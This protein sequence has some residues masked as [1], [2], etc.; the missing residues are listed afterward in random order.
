MRTEITQYLFTEN[1]FKDVQEM[2]N[3]ANINLFA[4]LHFNFS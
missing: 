2:E 4:Q 1:V 3:R